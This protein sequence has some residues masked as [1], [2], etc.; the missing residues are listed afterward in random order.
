MI[1]RVARRAKKNSKSNIKSVSLLLV[2]CV[3]RRF[4]MKP[5]QDL[6]ELHKNVYFKIKK[7]YK[8]KYSKEVEPYK[9]E[10]FRIKK[11]IEYKFFL[12]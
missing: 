12:I 11:P 5:V 9:F 1:K 4:T 3:L 8:Y 2:L 6:G 7:L 10:Y